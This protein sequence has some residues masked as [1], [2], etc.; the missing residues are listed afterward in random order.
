MT[1]LGASFPDALRS[2]H[3][4]RSLDVGHVVRALTQFPEITKEK[5]FVI[6]CL[7]PFLAVCFINSDIAPFIAARPALARC[8]VTIQGST[9]SF[10]RHTSHIVCT[11]V[12][13]QFTLQELH[14]RIVAGEATA[15][16]TL[17]RSDLVRVR[18]AL[19]HS[20]TIAQATKIHI[21]AA[22]DKAL[23]S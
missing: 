1:R 23:G 17:E 20:P 3:A 6:V 14:D 22:I 16:G 18:D 13:R 15:F 2:G 11:D 9:Y 5:F 7:Q 4:D 12:N 10:L 21:K 19:L 8:V